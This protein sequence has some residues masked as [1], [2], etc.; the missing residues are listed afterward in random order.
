MYARVLVCRVR[1]APTKKRNSQM[2]SDIVGESNYAMCPRISVV[3]LLD[4]V[5]QTIHVQE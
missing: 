1:R 4:W 2:D 5:L 3:S